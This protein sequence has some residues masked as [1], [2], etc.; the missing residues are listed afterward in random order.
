M[1]FPG[2]LL[3]FTQQHTQISTCLFSLA[4]HLFSESADISLFAY[5]SVVYILLRGGLVAF[6]FFNNPEQK[7]YKWTYVFVRML[8]FNL[9]GRINECHSWVGDNLKHMILLP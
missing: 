6:P 8:L 9:S 2:W 5:S 7:C 3:S 4:A 1:V